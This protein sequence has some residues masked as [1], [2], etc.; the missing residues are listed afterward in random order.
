M[1]ADGSI[2]RQL[3]GPGATGWRRRCYSRGGRAWLAGA[4]LLVVV[5]ASA[6]SVLASTKGALT[7][8][9]GSSCASPYTYSVANGGQIITN[10]DPS[11]NSGIDLEGSAPPG[12]PG[13]TDWYVTPGNFICSAKV[14]LADGSVVSPTDVFPYATPTPTGGQYNET[15]NPSSRYSSVT[16]TY[17]KSKLPLGASCTYPLESS[18]AQT[19]AH[20]GPRPQVLVKL[21]E[22]SP[23][24]AG[25]PVSLRL[26]LTPRKRNLTLCPKA[27]INIIVEDAQGH[28]VQRDVYTVSV[29]PH[30][31]LSSTITVP[32]GSYRPGEAIHPRLVEAWAYTRE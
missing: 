4:A 5:L 24:K 12:G 10:T 1:G 16:I 30:G 31:G 21:I 25:A 19:I 2:R 13:W 17:A 9:L 22:V 28:L 32:V 11:H 14:Q 23:V 8:A 7:S 3:V 15:S 6:A 27:D 18:L 29:K 26:K 20:T